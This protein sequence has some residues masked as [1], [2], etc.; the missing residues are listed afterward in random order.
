MFEFLIIF[1]D[2]LFL[3]LTQLC[4]QAHLTENQ[5][6]FQVKTNREIER[7]KSQTF[8]LVHNFFF[9]LLLD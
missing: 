1:A 9:F 3:T 6:C 5:I 8:L 7:R 4:T 2:N